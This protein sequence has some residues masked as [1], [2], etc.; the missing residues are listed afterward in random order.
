MPGNAVVATFLSFYF[1]FTHLS[2]HRGNMNDAIY[3]AEGAQGDN[4]G[5]GEG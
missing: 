4:I 1:M 3:D 2:V 5:A